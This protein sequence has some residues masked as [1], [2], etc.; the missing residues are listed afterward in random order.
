MY[1]ITETFVKP[2]SYLYAEPIP[3]WFADLYFFSLPDEYC[4]MFLQALF[5]FDQFG[6]T[7]AW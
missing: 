6:G 5:W 7:A 4:D 1:I 3:T 2:C